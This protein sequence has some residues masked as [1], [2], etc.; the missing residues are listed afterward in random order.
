MLLN[1]L[2]SGRL[3]PRPVQCRICSRHH[4]RDAYQAHVRQSLDTR[5]LH[6]LV[7]HVSQDV[8]ELQNSSGVF[9]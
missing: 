4:L 3:W 7:T 1:D 2:E 6:E 5:I 8:Q 9:D